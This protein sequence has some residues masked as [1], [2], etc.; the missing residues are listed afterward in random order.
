MVTIRLMTISTTTQEILHLV[1]QRTDRRVEILPDSSL[2]VLAKVKMAKGNIPFHLVTYNP[3]RRG[4]DYTIAY[5]CG[6]ILRLYENPPEERYEFAATDIGRK[7]VFRALAGNKKIKRM[8]L[9]DTAIR[10]VA[11]QLFNGLMTQL[12]SVPIGLRI[13]DWL[14]NE[15]P[16]LR[17][18]QTASLTKQ[19][20]DNVQ[21]LSADI[22]T[23]VPTT[24]FAANVAMNA[25][26]AL[27]C[28]R[29]LG[30]ELFIIPYRSAGFENSGIRLTELLEE[31]PAEAKHDRELVDAWA[32]ELELNGWYR[33]IPITAEDE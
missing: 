28:D 18:S 10:Q 24:V 4:A 29:L 33:W 5:E 30:R 2:S 14:W 20:Q 13:D 11:E 21:S 8:G 12:R 25:A 6:Y 7:A 31:V 3:N 27:L 17:E 32:E 26:Y 16:S 22:R 19:Q 9:P 15:C 23:S 1:E